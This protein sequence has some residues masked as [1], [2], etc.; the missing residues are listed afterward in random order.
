MP[1]ITKVKG[2]LEGHLGGQELGGAIADLLFDDANPS[3]K[4]AETFPKQLSDNPPFLNFP[5]EG[6]QVE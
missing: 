5:T 2:M 1:W 4:L 3:G 6:D